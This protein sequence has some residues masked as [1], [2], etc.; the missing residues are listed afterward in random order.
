MMGRRVVFGE[1]VGVI[2]TAATPIDEE[3]ALFDSVLYPIQTHVD[4][5]RLALFDSLVGNT[6][7]A[8]VVCLDGGGCL[9]M[10]HFGKCDSQYVIGFDW[11]LIAAIEVR[12][13]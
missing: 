5:A 12:Y 1:V 11:A 9:G 7:C 4:G 6:G 3:F 13:Q 10:P 2:V 8:C